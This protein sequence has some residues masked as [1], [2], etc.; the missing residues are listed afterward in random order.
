MITKWPQIPSEWSAYRLDD[1]TVRGSGHTPDRGTPSYWDGGIKWVSLADSNK[2]DQR[3][4]SETAHNIS[5]AGIENSSAEIHPA[6]TVLISR[7]AGVGK[8]AVMADNMAVS[9]H[10]IVWRCGSKITPFYLYYTLQSEKEFFERIAVGSTIKTIGLGIFRKLLVHLPPLPEQ[11]KIAD[12]LGTW[13]EALEKLDALIA[14]QDHRYLAILESTLKQHGHD[15]CKV[16]DVAVETGPRN[17]ATTVARVL[18]VTSAHGFVLPED[19]F[20]KQVASADTT[21]YKIVRRGEYAYNPSRIN[22]GSI[23]RLTT[24]DEGIVSPIYVVFA[25]ND[26]VEAD[27]FHHWLNSHEA[28][29]RIRRSA[30]G[31]VRD[32]VNFDDFGSIRFPLPTRDKQKAI[33]EILDTADAELRLLRQQRTA[34]DQQ[35]RGLMQQLLT[36]KVRVAAATPQVSG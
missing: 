25:L 4:I 24:Y 31:S 32:S 16:R 26:R 6:G 20:D 27:Y 1:I 28:R 5:E 36:G 10:F 9:Q 33:A 18:S 3:Y 34:L 11:Q 12:I 35:K 19:Y 14:A 30:Q 15:Y 21:N 23:A 8:S 13:D 29:S 22:V 7:D 17:R 2:L